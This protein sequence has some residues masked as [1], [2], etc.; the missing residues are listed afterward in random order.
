MKAF[1]VEGLVGLSVMMGCGAS[2]STRRVESGAA[3]QGVPFRLPVA[4]FVISESPASA[5]KPTT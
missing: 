5:D 4:S 1:R 3:V 2:L